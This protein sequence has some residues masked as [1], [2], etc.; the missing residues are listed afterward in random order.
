MIDL[1]SQQKFFLFKLPIRMLIAAPSQSGKTQFVLKLI[2]NREKLMKGK[3]ENVLWSCINKKYIPNELTKIPNIQII[4]GLPS[5]D[6]ILE[7]T[8][9]VIDDMQMTNLKDICTLFT[10]SS[11]HKNI[12]I[13]FLVQNLFF[14]NNY[15][16]TISLNA[17]HI[18]LF[19]SIRDVNQIKYLARQI[20]PES[21]NSF[22]SIY[23][24]A[25]TPPYAYLIIDL[26]QTCSPLFRIKSDIFNFGKYF[27]VYALNSDID[28]LCTSEQENKY[29]EPL[30]Y[31]MD[32]EK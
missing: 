29:K 28:S 24:T 13:F 26:S 31:S 17:S 19:K 25:T 14:S 9:L 30:Y 2:R 12:S 1:C 5:V 16:R 6:S 4:E 15:M 8:I 11:H 7:N 3:I 18:V 21:V 22:M 23:K 27:I 32:M 10:V 20:F